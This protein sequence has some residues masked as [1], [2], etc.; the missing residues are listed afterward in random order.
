MADSTSPQ[1]LF[2]MF[3][4]MANPFAFPLQNFLAPSLS[5][6]EVEKKIS[7]LKNV[8]TWLQTN[9]GM[10]ELSIKSLE[11]QKALLAPHS[12]GTPE[13]APMENPFTDPKNWPWNFMN[14]AAASVTTETPKTRTKKAAPK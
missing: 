12:A 6:E 9:L 4:K 13:P 5:V 10:L 11:Y 7:E 1:A 2:D 14:P 3:Q 8:Q